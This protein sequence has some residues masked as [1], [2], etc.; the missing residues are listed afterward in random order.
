[1]SRSPHP[2][3]RPVWGALGSGWAALAERSGSAVRLD[4]DHGPFAAAADG[5]PDSLAALLSLLVLGEETWLVEIDPPAL[6][7]DMIRAREARCVQMI[8]PSI[9]DALAPFD[10][11]PLGDEDAAE[12]R[13]LAALTKP[14]PFRSKTHRLGRFVGVRENGRLVA[15]AGERMRLGGFVE[16]SGVCTHPDHR[17]RGY[18]GGLMRSVAARILAESDTPFLHAYAT[19]R[20]AIALYETLGFRVRAEI[21]LIEVTR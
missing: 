4:R 2:L 3:D 12:M 16:V 1:M 20:G 18:A 15:M 6:P 10:I 14:G 8:A 21:M 9:D 7:A 17:G 11:V 13:A 5:S 19:N